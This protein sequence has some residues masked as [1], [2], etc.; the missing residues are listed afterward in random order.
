M[1]F[2]RNED[3]DSPHVRDHW[4]L[5]LR[6]FGQKLMPHQAVKVA[7]FQRP[8]SRPKRPRIEKIRPLLLLKNFELMESKWCY[9]LDSRLFSCRKRPLK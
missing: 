2:A 3:G 9:F 6:S 1:E 8:F 5:G 4:R 7:Y